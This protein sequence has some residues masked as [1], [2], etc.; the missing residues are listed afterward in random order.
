[1]GIGMETDTKY[2]KAYYLKHRYEI[3]KRRRELR[4]ERPYRQLA[5]NLKSKYNLTIAQYEA[6][7]DVQNGVCAICFNP[8]KKFRLH[9]DHNHANSKIRGLLCVT[10]NNLLGYAKD[11]PDLLIRAAEYLKQDGIV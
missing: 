1:M 6:L 9:V 4:Q 3:N 11:D 10:C 5:Y 7:V 8:S 2:N